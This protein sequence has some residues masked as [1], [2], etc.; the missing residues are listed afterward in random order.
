MVLGKNVMYMK[1]TKVMTASLWILRRNR[2]CGRKEATWASQ[3]KG[4][5][6]AVLNFMAVRYS[7]S[8]NILYFSILI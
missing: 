8:L 7:F 1:K 2:N 4:G 5:M 6:M 3:C